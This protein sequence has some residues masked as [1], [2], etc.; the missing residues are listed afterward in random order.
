MF[1]DGVGQQIAFAVGRQLAVRHVTQFNCTS[2]VAVDF[3]GT[4]RFSQSQKQ[5]RVDS[6]AYGCNTLTRG[7][8]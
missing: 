6:W 7:W 2:D 5:A 8:A 3:H 4:K 1:A